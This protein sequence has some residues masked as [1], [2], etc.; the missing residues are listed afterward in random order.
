MVQLDEVIVS[1]EVAVSE[2]V[3]ARPL[4]VDLEPISPSRL[5]PIR[6]DVRKF[7]CWRPTW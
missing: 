1:L 7:A 3:G 2:P 4:E 6:Q 5:L